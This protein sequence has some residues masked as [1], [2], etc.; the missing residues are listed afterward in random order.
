MNYREYM[1]WLRAQKQKF[2]DFKK[3][4]EQ[5]KK[6]NQEIIQKYPTDNHGGILDDR[7]QYKIDILNRLDAIENIYQ[8]PT[9]SRRV[10]SN[11]GPSHATGI[12]IGAKT[13][14]VKGDTISAI[15]GGTITLSGVPS[16]SGSQATYVIINGDD[17]NEYRYV[18][19][20]INEEIKAGDKVTKGQ[21]LGKMGDNGS[22]G[23]VH[24]HLEII[25]GGKKTDPL[26]LL[27]EK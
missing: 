19:L 7:N 16:W 5:R 17:G 15:I 13:A 24:L 2:L 25:I 12:D 11:F 6:N 10:T 9:E 1:A 3:R 27:P 22:P 20:D 14:G 8:W 23:Q 26:L 18:H 21:K 4:L